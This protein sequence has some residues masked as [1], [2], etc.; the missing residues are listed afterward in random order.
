MIKQIVLIGSIL[1]GGI[2][3]EKSATLPN[4]SIVLEEAPKDSI[5]MKE[6]SIVV[7]IGN[8]SFT[9]VLL[10]NETAKSF[11][12][13]LPLTL[14]MTELNANEKYASLPKNLPITPTV[15]SGISTGDLM[16]YGA[17]TFVLFY[18]PLSTT[19]SYTKLGSIID[20]SG[21]A[22]AVGNSDVTIHFDIK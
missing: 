8:Q 6:D 4:K 14:K 3:C 17:N 21:L 20:T 11:K 16:M 9:A 1:A 5:S 7:K 2:A 18:Q 12:A 19:Y 22:S 10:N 15:P 13:L